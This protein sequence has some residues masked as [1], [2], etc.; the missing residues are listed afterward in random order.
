MKNAKKRVAS[1]L[2]LTILALSFVSIPAYALVDMDP[3]S[4]S[5]GDKGD[6]IEVTGDGVQG[7]RVVNLYWDLVQDWSASEGAGLLNSSKAKASGEWEIWFD[8]PEAVYGEHYVYVEDSYTLDW[9]TETFYVYPKISLSSSS[10]LI[11]E[12]VD[13]SG[14][15]F[16]GDMD[17]AII[18]NNT[19]W[20]NDYTTD[21]DVIE[22]DDVETEFDGILDEKPIVPYSVEFYD[23]SNS[24]WDDGSGGLTTSYAEGS[25]NYVTGEWDLEFDYAVNSTASWDVDYDFVSDVDDEV[26]VLTTTPDTNDLGSFT[27]E[28]NVPS[29][30]D[31][32]YRITVLDG[33]GVVHSKAFEIGPVIT[34]TPDSGPVGTVVTV[35]GRGFNES[36]NAVVTVIELG[37]IPC[38]NTSEIT[39][40][41]RGKFKGDF[42][43]PLVPK[44]NEDY[45]VYASDDKGKDATAEFEVTGLPYVEVDPTSAALGDEIT[46]SGGNFSAMSEEVVELTLWES[47]LS[48]KV[49]DID[50]EDTETDS[51]GEFSGIYDV[52]PVQNGNYVIL[53]EQPDMDINATDKFTVGLIFVVIKPLSGTVGKKVTISGVGFTDD[54]YWNASFG[55]MEIIEGEDVDQGTGGMLSGNNYFYVPTVDPG[56]Y[57]I[58]VFGEQS[59]NEMEFDFE[60]TDTTSLSFDPATVPVGE[61]ESFNVS[62]DG[63]SFLYLDGEG[64][65]FIMYNVTSEGEIEEEWVLD[66]R[67]DPEPTD[68]AVTTDEDGVVEGW[69]EFF[70]EEDVSPGE[71]WINATQEG[72][73]HGEEIFVQTMITVI[74]ESYSITPRKS[75]FAIGD[76]VAFNLQN[77]FKLPGSFLEIFDPDG[78]LYW[79]TDTLS[80]EDWIKSGISHTVPYYSQTSNENSLL[81]DPDAPV[82]EWFWIFYKGVDDELTNGTFTVGEAAEDIL[83]RQIEE[84]AGDLTQLSEDFAGISTDVSALATDVQALAGSVSDAIAAANAATSAVQQVASAVADVADVAAAAAS[85]AEQA[86]TAASSAQEAANEAGRSASGLTTLVYGA[87]GA[88]LIAALAAIVSLMQI[89][90]RIAG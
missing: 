4:P 72:P 55:D 71:Y 50:L 70:F 58:T 8:V 51:N 76:T 90:R 28:I 53:A 89:S 47:D 21:F 11:G 46:I 64:I 41:T 23:G 62:V 22:G 84:L 63:E 85:A 10:G 33:E 13:V 56:V 67:M 65:E 88:S 19:S 6:T 82:G 69:F 75:T 1:I 54:D 78:E 60:V 36:G 32:D 57:T 17:V 61:E 44:K 38:Y 27:R 31:G 59:E 3:L 81:L 24:I 18:F 42:V 25:I 14:Y 35:E 30:D 52:P 29:Y 80:D 5:T 20:D 26:K 37:G 9:D 7:G 12:D 68:V 74:P 79:K 77:S 49:A 86:A 40:S 43:V 87:I 16:S 2:V 15:G 48:D 83:S 66:V 45:T 34:L 39:V 73:Q